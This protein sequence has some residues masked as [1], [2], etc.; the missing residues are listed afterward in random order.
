LQKKGREIDP[1]FLEVVAVLG[2]AFL[3]PTYGAL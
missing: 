1:P 3:N 2:F